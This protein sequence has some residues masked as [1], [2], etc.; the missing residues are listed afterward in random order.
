MP[1]LVATVVFIG[2]YHALGYNHV[3]PAVGSMTLL[4]TV[5]VTARPEGP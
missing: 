4:Y 2:I 5:A 1:A 3:A